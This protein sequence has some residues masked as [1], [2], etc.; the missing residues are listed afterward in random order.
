M[1]QLKPPLTIDEQIEL[2]RNRGLIIDHVDAAK[3][4][5][6]NVNYYR[7]INAYSLGLYKLDEPETYKDDVHFLNIYDLY[8]F[9]SKLRHI[10]SLPLEQFEIQFKTRLAYYLATKYCATCY[11]RKELFINENY[12]DKMIQKIE[13]ERMQQDSSPVVKHHN[14]AYD[15]VLPIWVL[16]EILSFGTVSKMY[17]NLN[18]N[19]QNEIAKIY[20][21]KS[22]IL[23]SW[24]RAFVEV[25]NICAHY[26]RL[27]NK[28]LV[29]RPILFND[30]SSHV[31]NLRVFSVL[32]LLVKYTS[33]SRLVDNIRLDLQN[34]FLLHPCVDPFKIGAPDNWETF[35]H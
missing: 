24:L 14:E 20:H 5:L 31:N 9:D 7:L 10:I 15:G 32:I 12:Y 13:N 33:D 25:R 22:Y 2:L 11:L 19:D 23:K 28:T 3:T 18:K 1:L 27:Y 35:L 4:V 6:A 8:R 17:A 16:V 30:I 26:G 34:A 21:V 29:S